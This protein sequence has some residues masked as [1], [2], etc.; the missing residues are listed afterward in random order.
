MPKEIERKFLVKADYKKDVIKKENIVQG[1]LSTV[2]E[3]T[4]RVRIKGKNG[5]LTIKGIGNK[6]GASRYEFEKKISFKDATDL[7]K[8]CEEG[9]IQKT[10]HIIPTD[11]NLFFEVVNCFG[12]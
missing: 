12:E 6:T 5:Y 11:N 8:I 1:F 7:L 4:V 3:R 10:R 2:A 9:V